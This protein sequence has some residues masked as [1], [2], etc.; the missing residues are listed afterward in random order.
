MVKA[1][2]PAPEAATGRA[3]G[4][5]EVEPWPSPVSVAELLDD[6]TLTIRRHVVLPEAAAVAVAGW[7]LHTYVYEQFQH[8]PR[9]AITS[10]AK[11]CGKSTLLDVLRATCRRPLKAD[12]ISAAGTFRTVEALSPVTLLIDEADAFLPQNEELRGILNS[13]FERSGEVIRVVEI[14]GEQQPV[15]FRTFAP[16][17]LACIGDLPGTLEDRAI[18]VSLQRKT[19][20]ETV[21]KLR[22][23]GARAELYDLARKAARWAA[24][25]GPHLNP[26]PAVPEAL[27][28]R[29]GDISVP[30]IAIA[31]DAGGGW[32]ERMRANLI[33]LFRKRNADAGAADLGTLLLADL[34]SLFDE[35]S[36]TRLPSAQIVERLTRLEDRPWSE[37]RNG[38]PI[39]PP[40]LAAAL[41]PFGVRPGTIRIGNETAKGYY[42]EALI[43]AWSRYLPQMDPPSPGEGW[44]EPAHRH[45]QGNSRLTADFEAVTPGS[46]VT[47]QK[48][49]KPA[50]NLARDGVTACD[51]LYGEKVSEGEWSCDL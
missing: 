4:L 38:R 51:P 26:D 20:G 44:S 41:R 37:F 27:G 30:L 28:D 5:P 15:T 33:T 36:A 40:Q 23:P 46:R 21:V 35:L 3:V 19:A 10:P 16:V 39:T 48:S 43:E 18:P 34:K 1:A 13:G 42:R 29:E 22:A 6:L 17:A 2:R 25:R 7:V 24:D 14:R 9:L 49:R 45:T 47:P 50:E 31:D 8:T 32:P 11:R 12:S